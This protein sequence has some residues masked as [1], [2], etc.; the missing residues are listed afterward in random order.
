MKN[1]NVKFK[2]PLKIL[3]FLIAIL[4]FVFLM[5][6]FV[7]AQTSPQ[8]LVSWQA[9]SYVP[10]WYQGKIIPSNGTSIEISFELIDN[11]KIVDLSKNKIRWYVNDKLVRNET[12]GLGIK[13][14]RFTN[15]SYGGSETEVHISIIDYKAGVLDKVVKIPVLGPEVV[16]NSPYPDKKISTGSSV[17]EAIPFFFNIKNLNNLS[18]DWSANNQKPNS[19]SD[20]PW[21][22]NLN[23]GPETPKDIQ[24]QLSVSVKNILR[25]LEFANK[26]IQLYVK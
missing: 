26:S 17:F 20:N 19:F 7:D 1:N 16:I 4:I 5:L 25:E 3:T 12:N 9:E 18:I 10:N 11:G 13:T 23:I 24:I 14:L 8:F 21:I 15:P 6:H 22:L 2:N